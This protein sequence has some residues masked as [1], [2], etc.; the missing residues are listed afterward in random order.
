M[1][2][3]GRKEEG[4]EEEERDRS[5]GTMVGTVWEERKTETL[6]DDLVVVGKKVME[7]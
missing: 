6:M 3:G 7:K 1:G 4:K 5:I 2:K